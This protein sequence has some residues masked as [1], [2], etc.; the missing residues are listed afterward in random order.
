MTLKQ[1][2]HVKP[3]VTLLRFLVRVHLDEASNAD[4]LIIGLD[5]EQIECDTAAFALQ[6]IFLLL[7]AVALVCMRYNFLKSSTLKIYF[8]ILDQEE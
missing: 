6:I 4:I 7:I 1:C 3:Y 5:F 8:Q 2:A